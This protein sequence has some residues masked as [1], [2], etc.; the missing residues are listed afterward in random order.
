MKVLIPKQPRQDHF[1]HKNDS[2]REMLLLWK[3]NEWIQLE[4][5]DSPYIWI[6][7]VG[8]ILL[9]DRARYNK[10]WMLPYVR[11][12]IGLFGNEIPQ[13][14]Y[15]KNSPW[16]FWGRHPRLLETFSKQNLVYE[17]RSIET[18]F[19]G[20][21][22]NEV[23]EIYRSDH[24]KQVIEYFSLI[25]G[26]IHKFTQEEY[27]EK[28]QQARFGLCCRGYGPKCH[29]EIEYM[30]LGV[31]P[32]F[33]D[34]VSS[35]YYHPLE[36]N[37]HYIRV[38]YPED[39]P[40][41]ISGIGKRLW[42]FMSQSCREY[43]QDYCS[44]KG[45]FETT[46]QIISHVEK[47]LSKKLMTEPKTNQ[48]HSFCSFATGQ[49]WTD[50][51]LFLH[52]Y[53]DVH[54]NI[55]LYIMVDDEIEKKLGPFRNQLHIV[56]KNCLNKFSNKEKKEMDF[57]EFMKVK[58]D[59]IEWVLEKE[60]NTMYTDADIV[61]LY[62]FD[63]YIDFSKDIGLSPHLIHS[64]N[65]RKYGYYNAGFLFVQNNKFPQWWREQMKTS[66]FDDQGCLDYVPL[67]FSFFEFHSS[68][69]FGWWRMFEGETNYTTIQSS[70]TIQYGKIYYCG[71]PLTSIHTHFFLNEPNMI[72]FKFNEF[73]CFLLDKTKST[74]PFYSTLLEPKDGFIMIQQ[75]YN[76]KNEERQ[77]E[78]DLC[79]Y[80]NLKSMFVKKLILWNETGVIVPEILKE[81]DK[82]LI[83]EDK[84]WI[85]YQDIINYTNQK[86]PNDIIILSNLDI[87]LEF[88][89]RF[90]DLY[91]Y[92][93]I[94]KDVVYC[95]SRIETNK[96]GHLFLEPSNEKLGYGN[97]QDTWIFR[98][99][100]PL[101]NCSIPLGYISCEN[102]FAH[103][104][105]ESGLIPV[106][107]GNYVPLIHV[108][109]CR[110]KTVDNQLEFHKNKIFDSTGTFMTPTMN[111]V[112][113]KQ[114]SMKQK[115]EY[116]K[117]CIEIN[118]YLKICNKKK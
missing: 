68:C 67:H 28:I 11:Y 45:S 14:Y 20:N 12:R 42:T 50:L 35:D 34:N 75:Y 116:F 108:D 80:S 103:C 18:I 117:K 82:L 54:Q 3:E 27:L 90:L 41:K 63:S 115:I 17:D 62:R 96:D 106:N 44:V 61:F 25:K 46:K 76:D 101:T 104:V 112:L 58:M 66:F 81:S 73:I 29:R 4:E 95:L 71:N 79:V 2:F 110:G 69:N 64:D 88:S 65:A 51:K 113:N 56:S 32:I 38:S 9:Y 10:K 59:L 13:P 98:G 33:T 77:K 21:I 86:Y 23:Q 30:A 91:H 26:S 105:K 6:N 114:F 39:I 22:E 7:K 31:V 70:F 99:D 111:F 107:V 15:L 16:I 109:I 92:L 1:F 24:W 40:K 102:S 5:T 47:R 118:K 52:S 100:V 60:K 74:Y 87:Y 37:V 8:D 89:H 57:K 83:E 19:I 85:N 84:P 94:E 78:L 53:M 43:Y 49:V 72:T 48:I 36:E 97:C 93:T 55:P